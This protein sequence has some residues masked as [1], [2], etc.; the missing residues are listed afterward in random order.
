ML[1][2][3]T[4]AGAASPTTA[5]T[6]T[7][8]QTAPQATAAVVANPDAANAEAPVAVKATE[9]EEG[10]RGVP[11]FVWRELRPG[12]QT[13]TR[14]CCP[15]VVPR[16][17]RSNESLSPLWCIRREQDDR[18][19]RWDPPLRE[20]GLPSIQALPQIATGRAVSVHHRLGVQ[21]ADGLLLGWGLEIPSAAC[22]PCGRSVTPARSG[23]SCVGSSRHPVE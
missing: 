18:R 14:R 3:S 1:T 23:R 16:I 4:P 9:V 10:S 6:V 2:P 19:M 5:E 22:T 12:G 13:K 11:A 20:D 21:R 7:S 8:T 15:G 17:A